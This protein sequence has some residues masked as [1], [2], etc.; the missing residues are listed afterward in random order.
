MRVLVKQRTF[1]NGSVQDP[2]AEI[3]IADHLY[4]PEVHD[5]IAAPTAELPDED[6][7]DGDPLEGAWPDALVKKGK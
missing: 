3:D 1:V 2:G 4:S 5:K 6:P 7:P